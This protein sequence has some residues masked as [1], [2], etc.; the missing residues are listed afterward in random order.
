MHALTF[1]SQRHAITPGA[2]AKL[3]QFDY[4]PQLL[5]SRHFACDW[6]EMDAHDIDQNRYALAHGQ[7]VLS[8]YT[9]NGQRFY[10]ATDGGFDHTLICLPDE[11]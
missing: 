4:K 10:V 5:L 9:I 8:A 7:Q 6:Q 3:E 1:S 2:K 11:Y